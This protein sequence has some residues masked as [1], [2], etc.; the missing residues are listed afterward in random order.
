MKVDEAAIDDE[1][2]ASADDEGSG[3]SLW[4][5]GTSLTD[6]DTNNDGGDNDATNFSNGGT[7][8]PILL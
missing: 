6:D 5:Q 7:F 8:I 4:W 1:D 3:V 2:I